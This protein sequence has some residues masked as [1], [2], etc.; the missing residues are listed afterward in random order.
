[1]GD[2][3]ARKRF[4]RFWGEHVL[5]L[6][7]NPLLPPAELPPIALPPDLQTNT[8]DHLTSILNRVQHHKCS[9]GYCL[10]KVKNKNSENP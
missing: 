2:E 4:A 5:A 9:D 10:R 6:N 1:M 8:K 3:D 7:P